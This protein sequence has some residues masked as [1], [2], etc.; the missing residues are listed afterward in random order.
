VCR[1][2]YPVDDRGVEIA[3]A[4]GYALRRRL[5]PPLAA[6]PGQWDAIE[7]S[8]PDGPDPY[9]DADPAWLKVDW[10]EHLH[11]V[12][13]GGTPITYVEIGEGRPIIFIHGLSGIVAKLAR[14]HP[15]PRESRLPGPG[16]RPTRVRR[17]P[18]AEG[19]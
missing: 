8:A 1:N 14:E 15:G 12:D 11:S 9:G 19:K 3:R 16:S 6:L 4:A 2:A 18:T 7:P 10:R 17:Q 13:V 5:L